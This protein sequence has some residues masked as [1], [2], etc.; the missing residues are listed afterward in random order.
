MLSLSILQLNVAKNSDCMTHLLN[1]PTHHILLLQE[2]FLGFSGL[3]CSD[4]NPEGTPIINPPKH[5]SWTCYLL[6]ADLDSPI[7]PHVLI[8]VRTSL[9]GLRCQPCP[10]L[11]RHKDILAVDVW[12]HDYFFHLINIYNYGPGMQADACCRLIS[13]PLDPLVPTM[14][15]GDFNL[16]HPLWSYTS[17]PRSSGASN[18]LVDWLDTAPFFLYNDTSTT[19]HHGNRVSVDSTIDL[20]LLNHLALSAGHFSTWLAMD[21][22]AY[23]SDHYPI[24]FSFDASRAADWTAACATHCPFPLDHPPDLPS[25]D[26][27]RDCALSILSAMSQAIS[28]VM[29]HTTANPFTYAY[30]WNRECDT[31]IAAMCLADNTFTCRLRASDAHRVFSQAKKSWAADLLAN[32][33]TADIYRYAK[34]SSGSRRTVCPPLSTPKGMVSSPPAQAAVFASTF[35]PPSPLDSE[36]PEQDPFDCPFPPVPRPFSPLTL[37]EVDTALVGTSS[38]SAPGPSGVS[39]LLHFSLHSPPTP[40]PTCL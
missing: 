39:Y 26:A 8:Y 15:C 21:D 12:F 18:E 6:V 36:V 33:T 34:W 19:T 14:V 27:T 11:F 30:W 28:E 25:A 9:P 10:D 24:T 3:C 13:T 37:S 29:P 7:K 38:T 35:F 40:I 32:A 1:D 23:L 22:P 2:P 20:T 5:P 4:F 31:A 17:D 16:H